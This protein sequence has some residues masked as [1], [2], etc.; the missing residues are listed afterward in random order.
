MKKYNVTKAI[1][2]LTGFLMKKYNAD[3]TISINRVQTRFGD[4]TSYTI[5]LSPWGR[6]SPQISVKITDSDIW[7]TKLEDIILT[8]IDLAM[9]KESW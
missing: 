1:N 7:C 3:I 5:V 9:A 8:K 2:E 6:K 4:D